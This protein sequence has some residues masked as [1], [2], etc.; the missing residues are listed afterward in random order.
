MNKKPD[1]GSKKKKDRRMI[2]ILKAKSL[3]S[4]ARRDGCRTKVLSLRCIANDLLQG[5][6]QQTS[7]SKSGVKIAQLN[8][9][10]LSTRRCF[11]SVAEHIA[12][13]RYLHTK[14]WTK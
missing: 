9:E 6:T 13:S 7:S 14:S 12:I 3:V 1:D 10:R 4:L 8:G 11:K 5:S 2:E